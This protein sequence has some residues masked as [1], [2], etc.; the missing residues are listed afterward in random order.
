MKLQ[1]TALIIASLVTIQSC[2]KKQ[3][4]ETVTI[5]P[6]TLSEEEK[7]NGWELL[8]DGSTLNGWKR[9]NADTI[10]PYILARHGDG[11]GTVGTGYSPRVRL[12]PGDMIRVNIAESK[13]GGLFSPLA[14]GGTGFSNVRVDHRGEISLPYAGHVPVAGLDT[15]GVED[16]IKSRLAGVTFE[17]QVYVDCVWFV[18]GR[19]T[20]EWVWSELY[21]GT[22]VLESLVNL[23]KRGEDDDE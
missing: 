18:E 9:Y 5:S 12:A 4:E 14:V 16:R 13:E 2:Q 17:P 15:S 11:G 23:S 7:N 20:K 3:K 19:C 22:F 6:N 10:G 8:F 21:T 1:T